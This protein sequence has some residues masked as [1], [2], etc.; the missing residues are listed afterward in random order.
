MVVMACLFNR[1]IKQFKN[2]KEQKIAILTEGIK[3][4]DERHDSFVEL[5]M[6]LLGLDKAKTLEKDQEADLIS[7]VVHRASYL[8]AYEAHV[9]K[10]H[11][12]M[13]HRLGLLNKQ[14]HMR[15]KN[16]KEFVVK[17]NICELYDRAHTMSQNGA[18]EMY[19]QYKKGGEALRTLM[20]KK[21]AQ[22]SE[23]EQAEEIVEQTA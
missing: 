17:R 6:G 4:R 8:S 14:K 11:A 21:K 1:H 12:E 16:I 2:D 9:D 20:E 10:I 18:Y 23:Q 19:S 7:L 15:T 3:V 13:V 5:I 22:D